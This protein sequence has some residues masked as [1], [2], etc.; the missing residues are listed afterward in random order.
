MSVPRFWR[1]IPAR[2]NL[3][4]SKCQKCSHVMFP[5]RGACSECLSIQLEPHK[6]KPEGKVI[7]HTTVHIPQTG[8]E[9]E[10][11]YT[12]AIIE[13]AE[14]PRLT[15]EIVEAEEKDIKIGSKVKA[16]FRRIG[17]KGRA[18]M[19]YYGYKFKLVK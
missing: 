18:G 5:S 19:I 7:S 4:G 13:L 15:A 11:P 10:V 9:H 17:E 14:G 1:G 3:I 8:F 12:L 6:F 16:C 2:Y